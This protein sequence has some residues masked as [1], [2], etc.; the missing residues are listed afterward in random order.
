MS[1]EEA[2]Q[3]I[4]KL[5]DA[6]RQ[7]FPNGGAFA[8]IQVTGGVSFINE[9][10]DT[11]ETELKAKDEQIAELKKGAKNSAEI[12]AKQLAAK[13]K[14]IIELQAMMQNMCAEY[15]CAKFADNAMTKE[16]AIKNIPI[17]SI[18]QD[19]I[20]KETIEIT[21][22]REESYM[23]GGYSP[24]RIIKYIL[25]CYKTDR[26]TDQRQLDI[27]L[28]QFEK[29]SDNYTLK[30]ELTEFTQ[31]KSCEGCTAYEDLPL[32]T[33]KAPSFSYWECVNGSCRLGIYPR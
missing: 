28:R 24:Y 27:F 21:S 31:E 25:I 19:K 23:G 17:G 32:P 14:K 10:Y 15:E 5:I 20:T 1:G 22:I 26:G 6:F 9:I 12:Y 8:A 4:K 13:D 11:H 18:W 30:T 16:K 7:E 3:K 2:T 33:R 29:Q